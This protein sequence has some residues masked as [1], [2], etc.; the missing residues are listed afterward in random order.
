MTRTTKTLVAAAVLAATAGAAQAQNVTL[1]GRIDTGIQF[2]EKVNAA[3]DS[4]TEVN[5]GG[6]LPSIWGLKGT[7]DLGGGLKAVFNLEADFSSDTGGERFGGALRQFGR[8]ANVGV[9]G[10]FGTILLGRQYAPALLAELGVEPRGYK[11]SYSGLLTYALNQNPTG[12][13]ISGNNFLGIFTGNMVSYSGALGPVNVFAGY[14]LGENASSSDGE[15]ISA[16]ANTTFGPVTV[17]G[18]YQKIRGGATSGFAFTERYAVGAAV[19]FGIAKVKV[20]YARADEDLRVSA[21]TIG[22]GKLKTD[23]YGIGV[24]LALLPKSTTTLAYYYGESKD[25]PAS[26]TT[27]S[28][29]KTFVLSNDY[30]LSKRTTLYAQLVYVDAGGANAI[31]NEVSAGVTARNEKSSIV[32]VGIKH[33]F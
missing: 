9:S 31:R 12:N 14:G 16:G 29:S 5:N 10:G 18:S 25:G 15:T 26:L 1:F 8:Q 7:E 4:R 3:G 33:D 2:L 30:A 27:D 13:G 20:H 28:D 11:E 17:A 19:A 24:D 32:G 6:I 21:A 22:L 23:N